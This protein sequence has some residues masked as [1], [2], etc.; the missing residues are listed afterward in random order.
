MLS[1]FVLLTLAGVASAEMVLPRAPDT[2][3]SFQPATTMNANSSECSSMS[4]SVFSDAPAVPFDIAD[5]LGCSGLPSSLTAAYTTYLVTALSWA[6]AH[7][8]EMKSLQKSCPGIISPATEDVKSISCTY[9]GTDLAAVTAWA[10]PRT[11]IASRTDLPTSG[12][13]ASTAGATP[14]GATAG[15][16]A[17]TNA[18][19]RET[20]LAWAAV[21]IAGVLGAVAML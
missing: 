18:G 5:Y 7:S 14:T 15:G 21:A 11:T 6:N 20:G 16:D 10:G 17:E 9:T 12:T 8:D 4:R 13:S 1:Q 2:T 19:N 3:T